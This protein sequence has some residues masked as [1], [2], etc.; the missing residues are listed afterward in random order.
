MC[1]ISGTKHISRTKTPSSLSSQTMVLSGTACHDRR[2]HSYSAHPEEWLLTQP[3][4][5]VMSGGVSQVRREGRVFQ[6]EGIACAKHEVKSPRKIRGNSIGLVCWEQRMCKEWRND[7]LGPNHS[8]PPEP[9][10]GVWAALISTS[11]QRRDLIK[12]ATQ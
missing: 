11:I 5:E 3:R 2:K 4:E 7:G 10:P 12:E 8:R 6:A 9:W 1:C